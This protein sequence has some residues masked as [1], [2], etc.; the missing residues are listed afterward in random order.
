[1]P[2]AKNPDATEYYVYQLRVGAVPFYVG[3]GR[4][5]RA[6]DRVRYVKSLLARE[7][8]GRTVRWVL[9]NE[10]VA[11]LIQA[12]YEPKHEWVTENVTR[13]EALRAE[14]A[15]IAR[16]GDEGWALANVHH[17]P[18]RLANANAI[19]Q[20]VI[21]RLDPPP[22]SLHPAWKDEIRRRAAELDSGQVK[23]IP[24]AEVQR[25]ALAQLEGRD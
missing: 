20:A 9:S 12:G 15:E 5:S 14:K 21:K 4:L 13:S 24:W 8:A 7:E 22:S 10:V 3:I 23:P 2:V 18:D 19:V 1:M 25:S 17:N 11:R 6:S 16:L